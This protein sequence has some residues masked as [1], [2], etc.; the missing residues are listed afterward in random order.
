MIFFIFLLV[1]VFL[2]NTVYNLGRQSDRGAPKLFWGANR[3]NTL[4]V[5]IIKLI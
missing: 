1:H 2:S 4:K 5:L 3:N